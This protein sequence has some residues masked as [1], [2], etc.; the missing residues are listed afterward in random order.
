MAVSTSWL[1]SIPSIFIPLFLV[2]ALIYVSLQRGDASNSKILAIVGLCI[3]LALQIASFLMPLLMA[4]TVS[5]SVFPVVYSLHLVMASI[6]SMA[7]Y[8]FLIAAVFAGRKSN[9][10]DISRDFGGAGVSTE[11]PYS[12]SSL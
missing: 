2:A 9:V 11:N 8:S 1:Y 4:R 6:L 5:G 7:G 12:A 10:S 3:F